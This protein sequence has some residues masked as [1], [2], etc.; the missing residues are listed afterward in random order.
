[1]RFR[2]RQEAGEKLALALSRHHEANAVVLAIPR[3][4]VVL[5]RIIADKLKLTL[6]VIVTKKITPPENEEY[7]IGAVDGQHV[8]LDDEALAAEGLTR[9]EL[10]GQ[11]KEKQ[12][13]VQE[14]YKAFRG[15]AAPPALKGKIAILVDDGIATGQTMKAAVMLCKSRMAAR[16]IVAVPVAPPDAVAALRQTADEVVCLSEEPGFMAVGEFYEDFPQV[17]DEEVVALLRAR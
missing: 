16:V 10:E 3:G 14:R 12:R 8:L 6:D 11:I 15:K 2:D 17:E 7:A 13:A 4:G 5:G 1:M 9:K